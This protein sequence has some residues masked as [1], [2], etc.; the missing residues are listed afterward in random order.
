ME[1][2][3][4]MIYDDEYIK[5]TFGDVLPEYIDNV[6]GVIQKYRDNHWWESDNP[7]KVAMHQTF[8]DVLLVPISKFHKGLEE[9]LGRPVAIHEL[10]IQRDSLEKIRTEAREAIEG[11]KNEKRPNDIEVK[12][13]IDQ[14]LQMAVDY[15]S[16]TGTKLLGAYNSR[17]E[18]IL[19]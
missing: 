6:R 7:L 2:Q 17:K 19:N 15:C 16:E 4:K 5:K 18:V 3:N 11:L 12:D 8:E 9:L 1:E 10:G 13:K 14:S